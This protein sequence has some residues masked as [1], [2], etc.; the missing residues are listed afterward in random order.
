MIQ[1]CF[2]RVVLLIY[3]CCTRIIAVWFVG[4]STLN[5]TQ[6]GSICFHVCNKCKLTR[7]KTE[8]DATYRIVLEPSGMGLDT[9]PADS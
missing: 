3:L 6:G 7:T 4:R 5:G 8:M 9:G 2:L 1:S